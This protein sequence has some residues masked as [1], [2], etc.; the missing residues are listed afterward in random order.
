MVLSD[1]L[2]QTFF[3]LFWSMFGYVSISDIAVT[4]P[5][6][7]GGNLHYPSLFTRANQPN[8]CP[9]IG[10]VL[11]S[12]CMDFFPLSGSSV[13]FRSSSWEVRLSSTGLLAVV[14]ILSQWWRFFWSSLYLV[15]LVVFDVFSFIIQFVVSVSL[16][17]YFG[18]S[19]FSF[20]HHVYVY[21]P[22]CHLHSPEPGFCCCLPSVNSV[23]ARVT[24]HFC[25]APR[26]R[27]I[28][29]GNTGISSIHIRAC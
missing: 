6:P 14:V 12:L 20:S 7:G 1:S 9:L 8:Y 26:N 17:F 21:L 15:F 5:H 29:L 25:P 24:Q 27:K 16:H 23:D 13:V 4:Q 22:L 10:V 28:S 11:L 3:S 2:Q 19:A 18:I